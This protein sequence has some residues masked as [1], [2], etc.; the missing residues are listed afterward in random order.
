M[1]AFGQSEDG[2]RALIISAAPRHGMLHRMGEYGSS[3]LLD[4]FLGYL[5]CSFY[6]AVAFILLAG[7]VQLNNQRLEAP[8]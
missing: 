8:Y 3:T 7:H 6:S 5:V 4:P 1:T 2:G